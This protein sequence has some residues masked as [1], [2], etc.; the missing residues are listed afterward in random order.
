[1]I[2]NK[3]MKPE[4]LFDYVRYT[5]MIVVM[6][7][8]W[9]VVAMVFFDR[10]I[11]PFAGLS[12]VLTPWKSL[13]AVPAGADLKDRLGIMREI[14]DRSVNVSQY[15]LVIMIISFILFGVYLTF[16]YQQRQRKLNENRLLVVKNREIARRNELIRYMSATISH[17]FKNNLARIKRRL[18]MLQG[19][20]EEARDR[21]DRNFDKLF[22]DIEIFKRISDEREAGVIE[23]K[24]VDLDHLLRD[25]SGHFSDLADISFSLTDPSVRPWIFASET[26]LRTVFENVLDNAIRYKKP[27]EPKAHVDISIAFDTDL[28]RRYISISFRDQG[29]GMDEQEAELCFY[30]GKKSS[31]GWGQGLYFAKYVVGLHAGKIKI[32]KD[33]TRRGVGTE[34]IVNLPFVE[35]VASV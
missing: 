30:K 9:A 26:L 28:N 35:E 16:L 19:L 11:V 6:G 24:G 15:S 8:V 31:E 21:L 10:F 33:Y 4:R 1:M 23:F 32:G 14:L 12:S 20:P 29:I 17:E 3:W 2:Y 7:V 13:W 25:L 22:A 27:A 18:G 5:C 34:I